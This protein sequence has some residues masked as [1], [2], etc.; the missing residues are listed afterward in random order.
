MKK[1][2]SLKNLFSGI[3]IGASNIIP[4]VSGGTTAVILGIYED[5]INSIGNLKKDF[6]G[7]M[8]FLLQIGIGALIGI[9]GFSGIISFLLEEYTLGVNYLFIGFVIGSIGMITSKLDDKKIDLKKLLGFII[10]VVMV[11]LIY[12]MGSV[13]SQGVVSES[14]DVSYM[15]L[16]F[17][18]FVTAFTMILP[19]VSGSL[20]LVMLGLY[21]DFVLALSTFNI[22][23]LVAGAIG[24]IIGLIVTVKLISYLIEHYKDITYAAI[25]GLV[26]GSIIVIM[27]SNPVGG[28]IIVPLLA[29]F[30]GVLI[31]STLSKIA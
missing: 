20:S 12:F 3:C 8:K 25:L 24:G 9:L 4:G 11:A 18:G 6:K 19:G 5:L 1:K 2:L 28:N 15:A 10:G 7:S 30:S 31:T 17:A 29:T 16:V 21:D 23:Y 13:M 14:T 22:P 26:V 27:V